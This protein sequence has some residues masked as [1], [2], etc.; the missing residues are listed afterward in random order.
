MLGRFKALRSRWSRSF[1]PNLARLMLLACAAMWGASYLLAKF[2]MAEIPPQWLM[3]IR[4]VGACSCMFA[5]FHRHIVPCLNR[6]IIVPA[7]VAGVTYWG[8]MVTQTI[9]L[10]TIDPGRSSFLTAAYCV[11]T[12]FAAWLVSH[13]RPK[14]INV[15]AGVICLMGVGFVSLRDGATLSLSTGDWLTLSTALIFSF[16]LTCL[17]VYTKR[18]DPIAVTFVQFAV[19]GVLFLTGAAFTEPGPAVSWLAPSVVASVLYLFLG[20]TMAA[21]IMQNIGL[22][23][24]PASQASIIMCTESLFAVSFSALF[25]GERITWSSLVGFALIFAAV[26]MSV[27]RPTRH[28]LY[29]N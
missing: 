13:V 11:I 23:H 19:A 5:L 1:P 3:G 16:N 28:S 12:P 6:A 24:V 17:G 2:A 14:A 8:T 15:V 10:Q 20:A 26:L 27:I 18:F 4:M 9:G 21:Q 22:A 29:R 25:W 7:L